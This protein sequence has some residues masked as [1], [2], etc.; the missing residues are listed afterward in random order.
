LNLLKAKNNRFQ[1]FAF[2]KCKCCC[3]YFPVLID[4]GTGYFLEQTPADGVD[5]SRRKVMLLKDNMVR[6]GCTT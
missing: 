3:R 5:Y 1:A 2:H 6:L 4:V